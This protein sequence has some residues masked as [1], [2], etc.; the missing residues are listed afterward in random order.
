MVSAAPSSPAMSPRPTATSAAVGV[1]LGVLPFVVVAGLVG[2][3]V[4]FL[5]RIQ[6]TDF[7]DQPWVRTGILVFAPL[8]GTLA[9]VVV[10]VLAGRWYRRGGRLPSDRTEVR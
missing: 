1:A 7:L 5:G 2:L 4:I 9:G 6:T 10:G 3:I 8:A